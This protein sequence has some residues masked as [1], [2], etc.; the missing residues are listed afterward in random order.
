MQGIFAIL[1]LLVNHSK[2]DI[3]KKFVI[4][5]GTM[6]VGKSTI[7]SKLYK[8][9]QHSVWLDGDWCW[10]MNPWVVTEENKRW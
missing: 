9:L 4:V 6:G 5:N 10:L 1:E 3:M 8:E 2:E 7:V